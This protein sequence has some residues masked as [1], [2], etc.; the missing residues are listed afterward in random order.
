[1]AKQVIKLTSFIKPASSSEEVQRAVERNT[2]Q[3]LENNLLALQEHYISVITNYANLSFNENALRI[4]IAW[5]GKR[6]KARFS[7][8]TVETMQNFFSGEGE[9]PDRSV[10]VESSPEISL[11]GTSTSDFDIDSEGD[12]PPLQRSEQEH[13]PS[14]YPK[15]IVRKQTRST[16]VAL[17]DR[18]RNSQGPERVHP[19]PRDS[20]STPFGEELTIDPHMNRPLEGTCNRTLSPITPIPTIVE[21]NSAAPT[22][23][24]L[25]TREANVSQKGSA[26]P[27]LTPQPSQQG[28]AGEGDRQHREKENRPPFRTSEGDFTEGNVNRIE[29]AGKFNKSEGSLR[30]NK[31]YSRPTKLTS[32]SLHQPTQARSNVVISQND[33]GLQIHGF[34]QESNTHLLFYCYGSKIQVAS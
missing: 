33:P 1:M 16:A 12:F 28:G 19:P 22:Q 34:E 15:V 13:H 29:T 20:Q 9:S 24:H 27:P 2:E 8:S 26:S 17:N 18:G 11:E 25:G 14:L 30:T 10:Y 5:A 21:N 7:Q 4:A 23:V 6:Y 3:W 31:H 32:V